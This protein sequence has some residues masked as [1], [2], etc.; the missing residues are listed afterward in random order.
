MLFLGS[1]VAFAQAGAFPL[2]LA[3]LT[4]GGIGFAGFGAMQSTIVLYTAEPDFRA[5]TMGV[6]SVC[7]GGGAPLGILH[8]GLLADW[9]GAAGAVTVIATEGLAA[10][11]F[12]AW[13]W[14][15]LLRALPSRAA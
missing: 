14:P 10:L 9:L 5:R 12:A 11:A 3:L 7:I 1:V 2:A 8:V 6:I 15:E 4:V 13:R